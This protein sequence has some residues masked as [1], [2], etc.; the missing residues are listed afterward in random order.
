MNLFTVATGEIETKLLTLL[1]RSTQTLQ[2]LYPWD[3]AQFD[4]EYVALF[5]ILRGDFREQI[6]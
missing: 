6:L 3:S 5:Y 2:P 1:T 4:G